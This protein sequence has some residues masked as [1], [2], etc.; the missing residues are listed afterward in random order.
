MS[1]QPALE[2]VHTYLRMEGTGVTDD[3]C[4][5]PLNDMPTDEIARVL[6]IHH[7]QAYTMYLRHDL[8]EDIQKQLLALS[9]E[10]AFNDHPTVQQLLQPHGP[11]ANVWT[12]KSYVFPHTLSGDDYRDAVQLQA[13]HQPLITHYDPQ[14]RCDLSPVHAII[15]A[16]QI[17]ATCQASHESDVGAEAW[18]RTLPAF[19]KRGFGRQVTAAWAHQL[20]QQ[21]KL[22]FYSHHRDN[23]ASQGLAHSLGLRQYM[24]DVAY[25]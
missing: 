16:D 17:C 13:I 4:L 6:V 12:G 20:Q 5:F 1:Q 15:V 21:G 19:R 10:R 11:S 23:L 24:A 14:L 22:P 9:A 18:V 8:P 3:G 2:L 7:D 25:R